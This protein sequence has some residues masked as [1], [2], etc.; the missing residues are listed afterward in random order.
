VPAH[1]AVNRQ[2]I[3]GH[4]EPGCTIHDQLLDAAVHEYRLNAGDHHPVIVPVQ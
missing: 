3:I 4:F 2:R 1:V